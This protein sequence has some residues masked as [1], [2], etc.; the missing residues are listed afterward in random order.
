ML[1]RDHG[2]AAGA[3]PGP[4][5]GLVPGPGL[6]QQKHTLSL[7]TSGGPPP[8]TP[9]AMGLPAYGPVAKTLSKEINLGPPG[10]L[11]RGLWGGPGTGAP[12]VVNGM[13]LVPFPDEPQAES[14]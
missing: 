2:E 5:S 10:R 6:K 14:S 12:P 13:G 8:R 7:I 3:G 9:L 4:G 11:A 1:L